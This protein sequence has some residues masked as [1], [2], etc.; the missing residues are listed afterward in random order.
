ME[1]TIYFTEP[2]CFLFLTY[3]PVSTPP[4]RP[5]PRRQ[6]Y[7]PYWNQNDSFTCKSDPER[8]LFAY[9]TVESGHRV[10]SLFHWCSFVYTKWGDSEDHWVPVSPITIT[11]LLGD[12]G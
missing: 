2:T 7:F 11:S 10:K 3:L 9:A 1:F 12:L 5:P 8:I 6:F 4:P